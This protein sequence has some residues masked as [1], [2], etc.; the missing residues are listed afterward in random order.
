MKIKNN[1]IENQVSTEKFISHIR[2]N[3]KTKTIVNKISF[4]YRQY[5]N[6]LKKPKKELSLSDY[7]KNDHEIILK[8][9]NKLKIESIYN[10][11]EKQI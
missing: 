2:I 3:L 5:K 8:D 6:I 9:V 4:E 11:S 1:L 10:M 7:S